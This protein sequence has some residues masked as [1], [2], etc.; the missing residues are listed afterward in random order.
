MCLNIT[1]C[2]FRKILDHSVLFVRKKG[3]KKKHIRKKK[4]SKYK[5]ERK[6]G[7][8]ERER[9]RERERKW[10]CYMSDVYCLL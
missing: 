10:L 2:H 6:K 4:E 9:E 8:R 5:K 7:K 1:P 3:K